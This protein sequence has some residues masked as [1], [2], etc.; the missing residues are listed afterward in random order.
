MQSAQLMQNAI[1]ASPPR[2]L[3]S[4]VTGQILR[5]SFNKAL[6]MLE[7]SPT[8]GLCQSMYIISR[9]ATEEELFSNYKLFEST[10]R[11][12]LGDETANTTLTFLH[13]E[14]VNGLP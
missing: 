14:I 11:Q 10:L 1:K 13:E 6:E 12:L 9:V 3:P 4:S 5:K 8:E 7:D 2:P